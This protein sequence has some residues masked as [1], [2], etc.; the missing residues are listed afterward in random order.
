VKSCEN[1]YFAIHCNSTHSGPPTSHTATENLRI[2]V[3]NTLYSPHYSPHVTVFWLY[4][5]Q[6]VAAHLLT[7]LPVYI[8]F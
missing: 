2:L 8:V 3:S 6:P 7:K 1:Y 5:L 4:L